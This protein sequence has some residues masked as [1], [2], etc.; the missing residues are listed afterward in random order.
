MEKP[1]I[2][3]DQ[4][5]TADASEDFIR[6]DPLTTNVNENKRSEALDDAKS[7]L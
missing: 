3:S 2:D 4:T 5:T 7:H 6:A 1:T